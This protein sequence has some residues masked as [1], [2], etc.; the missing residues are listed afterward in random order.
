MVN[1]DIGKKVVRVINLWANAHGISERVDA[2]GDLETFNLDSL[3]RMDLA[4]ELDWNVGDFPDEAIDVLIPLVPS[5]EYGDLGGR[6]V[7]SS[8]VQRIIDY[9]ARKAEPVKSG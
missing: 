6:Y 9:Y 3:A 7:K 2:T 8:P 4:L 1:E 5:G